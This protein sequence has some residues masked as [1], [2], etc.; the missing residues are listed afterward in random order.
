MMSYFPKIMEN[1]DIIENL[2]AMYNEDFWRTKKIG[3]IIEKVREII[4]RLYP[5]I[6]S[7]NFKWS[8]TGF[9]D[10]AC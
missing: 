5:V 9:S 10:S 6:Y 4:T 1:I 3:E 7:T 2:V 8:E